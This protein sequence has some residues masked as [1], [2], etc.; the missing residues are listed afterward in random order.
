MHQNSLLAFFENGPR[1]SKRAK[2]IVAL[3]ESDAMQHLG[4]TDRMVM[5]ALGFSDPN[6]VRPR[7]TE[8]IDMGL[9]EECGDCRDSV[10]GQRVRRVRLKRPNASYPD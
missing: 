7:I 10:S 8:L 4:R 5:T 6:A 9:L 3:L 1:L 2:A